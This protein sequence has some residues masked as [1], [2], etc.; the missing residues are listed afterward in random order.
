MSRDKDPLS[1]TSSI[2]SNKRRLL[3]VLEVTTRM[4]SARRMPDDVD[5]ILKAHWFEK[6]ENFTLDFDKFYKVNQLTENEL[7]PIILFL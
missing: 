4:S 1:I 5:T 7:I 3:L 2:R 6:L